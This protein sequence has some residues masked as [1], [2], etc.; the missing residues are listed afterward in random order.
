MFAALPLAVAVASMSGCGDADTGSP[1]TVTAATLGAQ[2]LRSTAEYLAREPYISADTRNGEKLAAQCRACHTLTTGGTHGIGPGL[3][4]IFGRQAGGARDFDYS[5]A[6]QDSEFHWTPRALD[7]WLASPYE[8]LPGNRMTF[9][10]IAD[11]TDRVDLV[12]Y[13]L[14]ETGAEQ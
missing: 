1:A 7:A 3:H 8:F 2:E 10:G 12:A 13:L 5:A 4:G 6:L 14:T 11:A 9:T